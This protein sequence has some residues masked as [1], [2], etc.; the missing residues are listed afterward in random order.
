MKALVVL[1]SLGF[2]TLWSVATDAGSRP[3]LSLEEYLKA[4]EEKDPQ[5]RAQ[6]LQQE[7]G[8]LEASK[9]NFGISPDLISKVTGHYTERQSFGSPITADNGKGLG[10][11]L[12]I[13]QPTV[14]GLEV[15]PGI[16]FERWKYSGLSSLAGAPIAGDSYSDATLFINLRQPLWSGGFGRQKRAERDL[17]RALASQS[18][19]AGRAG[20]EARLWEAKR[21]YFTLVYFQNLLEVQGKAAQDATALEKW[22]QKRA[23]QNLT[24]ESDALQSRAQQQRRELDL[25]STQKNYKEAARYF[26]SLRGLV[27]D[28]V[29]E[30]LAPMENLKKNLVASEKLAASAANISAAA[31]ASQASLLA[32][33]NEARLNKEISRPKLDLFGTGEFSALKSKLSPAI[34]GAFAGK[35]KGLLVGLEMVLP[36]NVMARWRAV[37]SDELK[38]QAAENSLAQTRIDENQRKQNLLESI[39]SL[40][41]QVKIAQVLEDTQKKKLQLERARHRQGRSTTFQILSFQQDYSDIQA[42]RLG[43]E[44]ALLTQISELELFSVM[45]E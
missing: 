43:L 9:A 32:A 25:A 18:E 44:L 6:T 10:A 11:E 40:R 1:L 7:A 8:R 20:R 36:L 22:T 27:S 23:N 12:K 16:R 34:G 2:L 14:I 39:S 15:E 35:D 42:Q 31:K 3:L 26:N 5:T 21:A 28:E 13:R 38:V 24:D 41:E 4:V 37:K 30:N 33:Q 19:F 29:V 17:V 45:E